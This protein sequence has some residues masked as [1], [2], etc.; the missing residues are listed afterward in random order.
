MNLQTLG[1]ITILVC[2]ISILVHISHYN[3]LKDVDRRVANL[4]L[5]E[6][7]VHFTIF[8]FGMA[9]AFKADIDLLLYP[10]R[11]IAFLGVIILSWG[12]FKK[13]STK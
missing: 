5:S 2:T 9:T 4:L 11:I 6:G 13:S 8:L 1:Y 10:L 12:L 7:I 3:R